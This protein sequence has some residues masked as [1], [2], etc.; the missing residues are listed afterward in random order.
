MIIFPYYGFKGTDNVCDPSGK[1]G[2]SRITT[3]PLKCDSVQWYRHILSF[4]V[5]L[6]VL[7]SDK[8]CSIEMCKSLSHYCLKGHMKLR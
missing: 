4:F 7:N 1:D 2:K 8:S 6:K 5:G 3:V